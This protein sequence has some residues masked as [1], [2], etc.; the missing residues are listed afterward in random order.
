MANGKLKVYERF[1]S[2]I[3]VVTELLLL[4]IAFVLVLAC[5]IFV[6]AEFAFITVN[7]SAV[8]HLVA[9]GDGKAAGVAEALRTLSTQL[10]GAQ[11]GITITNLAIGFLAEPTI[12][13]LIG[14]ALRYAG[15]HEAAIG[16]VS[17]V[18]GLTV[19]TIVTM[20]LGELIPKNLAIAKPMGMARR[21]QGPARL[22][23]RV[24]KVP[25][26]VLN[27]SANWV[28][29]R[30]GVE[31]QEQLASARSA[32]ELSSLVRRSAEKGTLPKETALMLERTLAF[33]E[34][35]ALD[36]MTPRVHM[37]V[38]TVEDTASDVLALA[39]STGHS[40]FP[41]IRKGLDDVVGIV[42]I[43]NAVGLAKDQRSSV[44]V[45]RIMKKPI[46]VPSSIQL[47]PLLD[48]LRRG[49]LQMAVVIDEFGGTDG[50]VTIEDLLEELVGEVRDEHD[51]LGMA[52]RKRGRGGWMVSGLLR[53]DEI[54]EELGIFL[55]E[56]EE[57]ETLGGLVSDRLERIPAVGDMANIVAVNREGKD[58]YVHL[59]V[60]RMDGR[61]VDRVLLEVVTK[62]QADAEERAR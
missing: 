17:V 24:M 51:R 31:P 50:V 8:E 55:P 11:V 20:V 44:S 9:K 36:I 21:V 43:K 19:A 25:I 37:K 47:D 3:P 26:I 13:E 18:V 30:L 23:S 57:F 34:L 5:G 16:P 1:L 45:E 6:A 2:K 46:A 28:V 7:R 15:V 53:P 39:R 29:R 48:T 42:H 41:V 33:G 4:A 38:L 59:R 49:G 27:H 40:R 14:P 52:I 22:F 35:T 32:D 62:D 12:A 10:S 54:G 56:E 58:V 60:E 61:R